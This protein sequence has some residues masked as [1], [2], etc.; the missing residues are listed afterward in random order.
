MHI[1]EI[2]K[3]NIVFGPD[4]HITFH[5]LYYLSPATADSLEGCPEGFGIWHSHFGEDLL[6][7]K[8]SKKGLLLD[9]GWYPMQIRQGR[10][11]WH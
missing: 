5:E 10:L 8:S 7:M 11:A 6:L 1:N 2:N 3:A 9:V 4:W